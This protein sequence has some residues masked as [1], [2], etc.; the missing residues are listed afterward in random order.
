[1]AAAL[2]LDRLGHKIAIFEWF[3]TPHPLGSGLLIQPSGQAV[4]SELGLLDAIRARGHLVD[5]LHGV[6]LPSGK[7]ALDMQYRYGPKGISALGIHRASLFSALSDMSDA[8]RQRI[9]AA[10]A[11]SPLAQGKIRRLPFGA[12]WG[13]VDMPPDH[14]VLSDALDQR[15]FHAEKM[16]GIMPIGINPETGNQGAALFWSEKPERAELTV[17]RDITEFQ[18][19]YVKLWPEAKPFVSQ[20]ASMDD[21]TMAVYHHRTGSACQSSRLLFVGDSWHCTSPQLGQGAN[22]ALIDAQ[23][24]A[25]ALEGAATI[26]AIAPAYMQARKM[27]ISLYQSLSQIFTPLYQSENRFLPLFRDVAIHYFARWP[28]IRNFIAR[29][30]SGGLGL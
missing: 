23:V 10:G 28:L 16:A 1:M 17:E 18:N 3:E 30:V 5:R 6:S 8:L 19:A 11:R 25:A 2:F 22:M 9:D 24:L 4:L 15:Y 21:L 29:T 13:N 7:R 27:H 26:K 14:T 20:L 12:F